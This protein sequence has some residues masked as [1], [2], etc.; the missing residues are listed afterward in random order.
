VDALWRNVVRAFDD[1]SLPTSAR[2]IP[3]RTIQETFELRPDGHSD[4]GPNRKTHE[5]LEKRPEKKCGR[6]DWKKNL[7]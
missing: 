3:L 1:P 5:R 4:L 2:L 7:N 6:P